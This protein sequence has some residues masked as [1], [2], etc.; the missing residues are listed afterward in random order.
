VTEKQIADIKELINRKDTE[1]QKLN[2][3]SVN[4]T[5]TTVP[6]QNGV[7]RTTF[8]VLL[9]LALGLAGLSAYTYVKNNASKNQPVVS[10]TST[11]PDSST[12]PDQEGDQNVL[13]KKDKIVKRKNLRDT[14]T[15]AGKNKNEGNTEVKSADKGTAKTADLSGKYKVI[16]KAYF[17]NSPDD[18]THRKAFIVHWNNAVLTPTDEMRGFVYVVYTNDQGQ[19]SR[20][21]L[22][23]KDLKPAD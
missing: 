14:A 4:Q 20:G 16:S 15:T 3:T 5:E 11:E 12:V 13:K 1:V 21:W 22:R 6:S 7:S 19:T 8:F 18:S 10:L 23:K 9:F 2:K 17:Y